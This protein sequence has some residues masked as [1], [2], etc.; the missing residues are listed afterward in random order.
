[1]LLQA[2]FLIHQKPFGGRAPPGPETGGLLL[3]GG[4][5]R[6]GKGIGCEGRRG[7]GGGEEAQERRVE[8]REK[9]ERKEE[10]GSRGEGRVRGGRGREMPP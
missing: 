2:R 7:R 1:M 9:G 3:R 10:R 4:E 6:E 5:G 8:E